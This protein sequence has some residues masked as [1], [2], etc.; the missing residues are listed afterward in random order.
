V[1]LPGR[2]SNNFSENLA[3]SEDTIPTRRPGRRLPGR[4]PGIPVLCGHS[5]GSVRPIPTM[6]QDGGL[7]DLLESRQLRALFRIQ[8]VLLST[9]KGYVMP[10]WKIMIKEML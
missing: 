3:S 8:I 7:V 4:L 1:V 5:T 10:I 2:F 6:S 9:V